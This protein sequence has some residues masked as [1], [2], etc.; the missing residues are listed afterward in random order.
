[1]PTLPRFCPKVSPANL[2][3][4]LDK[5]LFPNLDAKAGEKFSIDLA[6]V[7]EILGDVSGMKASGL[8][9]MK[10]A[11][12]AMYDNELCRT[13]II[14]GG[15][16]KLTGSKDA[17][18]HSTELTP[19]VGKN[20]K[21]GTLQFSKKDLFVRRIASEWDVNLFSVTEDHL[22]FGVEKESTLKVVSRYEA[23]LIK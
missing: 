16:A 9:T 8:L 6:S 11:S 10:Y 22:L 17:V 20:G 12:D 23:E 2:S 13:A 1:M 5:F 4:I 15:S 19:K 21:P 14:E 18:K 7:P 3:P